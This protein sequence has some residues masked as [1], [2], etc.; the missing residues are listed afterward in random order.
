MHFTA[1]KCHHLYRF[2]Q[3]LHTRTIKD[4]SHCTTPNGERGRRA[5]REWETR[6]SDLGPPN[7][8]ALSFVLFQECKNHTLLPGVLGQ[9][10]LIF[11]LLFMRTTADHKTGRSELETQF[12][13]W[14]M[15]TEASYAHIWVHIIFL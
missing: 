14:S 5:Q 1:V 11:V 15:S 8:G 6:A 7:L 9:N 10:N 2:T 12:F 13:C 3:T 4:F